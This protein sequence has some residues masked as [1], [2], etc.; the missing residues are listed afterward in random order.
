MKLDLKLD[1]KRIKEYFLYLAIIAS[2]IIFDQVTKLFAVIFLKDGKSIKILGNFL[3]LE[4]AEN[5]GMAFGMMENSRWVFMSVS[6]VAI[7]AML[8]YIFLWK[9]QPKSYLISV[10]IIASGGIGNMIDRIALGYV[11]DFVSVKYFAVFNGADSLVC[12]GAG[13][14]VLFMLLDILKEAKELKAEKAKKDK[15]D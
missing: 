7:L 13:F 10:A 2:G 4:Y 5:E 15:K 6:C 1:K 12:V 9:N 11:V 3:K 8:I 14:L